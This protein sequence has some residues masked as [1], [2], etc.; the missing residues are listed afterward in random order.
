MVRTGTELVAVS[1]VGA[2]TLHDLPAT[3]REGTA[4]FEVAVALPTAIAFLVARMQ[5]AALCSLNSRCDGIVGVG[6]AA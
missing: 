6:A 1:A 4:G 5:P 3:N 2:G